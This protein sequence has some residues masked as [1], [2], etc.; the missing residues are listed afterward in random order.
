MENTPIHSTPM[1]RNDSSQVCSGAGISGQNADHTFQDS[2]VCQGQLAVLQTLVNAVDSNLNANLLMVTDVNDLACEDLSGLKKGEQDQITPTFVDCNKLECSKAYRR[3]HASMDEEQRFRQYEPTMSKRMKTQCDD[4]VRRMM[5]REI[6]LKYNSLSPAV[7]KE[8]I[9]AIGIPHRNPRE[10]CFPCIDDRGSVHLSR[11]DFL[12]PLSMSGMQQMPGFLTFNHV[13]EVGVSE[14]MESINQLIGSVAGSLS[15]KVM[16]IVSSILLLLRNFDSPLNMALCVST[17]AAQLGAGTF[18]VTKFMS[19]YSDMLEKLRPTIA[20]QGINDYVN[21]RELFVHIGAFLFLIVSVFILREIPGTKNFNEF[22]SRARFLPGACSGIKSILDFGRTMFGFVADFTCEKFLG[23]PRKIDGFEALKKWQKEVIEVSTVAYLEKI[24]TD[25]NAVAHVDN[26]YAQGLRFAASF[27]SMRVP[28]EEQSG[29]RLHMVS[30]S[31]I[32]NSAKSSGAINTMLRNEPLTLQIFGKSGVGKS[33]ILNLLATDLMI[34]RGA[35]TQDDVAN[36]LYSRKVGQE[37]WDGM[38]SSK[39]IVVYDDY[40]AVKDS[41]AKPNDELIELIHLYN[42]HPYALHM[43]ALIEKANTHFKADVVILTTNQRDF[44]ILSLSYPEAH[45]RRIDIR[46]ELTVDPKYG[47]ICKEGDDL[48]VRVDYSKVPPGPDGMILPYILTVV[49]ETDRGVVNTLGTYNYPQFRDFILAADRAKRQKN[50][51]LLTNLGAYM[52]GRLGSRSNPIVGVQTA[53]TKEEPESIPLRPIERDSEAIGVIPVPTDAD[54]LI[55]YLFG[56]ISMDQRAVAMSLF[57]HATKD[58]TRDSWFETYTPQ[59]ETLFQTLRCTASWMARAYGEQIDPVYGFNN[60]RSW[61]SGHS[62]LSTQ[63]Y[64]TGMR[65]FDPMINLD[66]PVLHPRLQCFS[67]PLHQVHIAIM[68]IMR[69]NGYFECGNLPRFILPFFSVAHRTATNQFPIN[70][71]SWHECFARSYG[72]LIS[73]MAPKVKLICEAHENPAGACISALAKV[74]RCVPDCEKNLCARLTSFPEKLTQ[75][76]WNRYIAGVERTALATSISTGNVDD[77]EF[78]SLRF[79]VGLALGLMTLLTGIGWAVWGFKILRLVSKWIKKRIFSSEEGEDITLPIITDDPADVDKLLFG[80]AENSGDP[81]TRAATRA[82]VV[83]APV[84]ENSGDPRTRAAPRHVVRESAESDV[85]DSPS[86]EAT[87]REVC[88]GAAAAVIRNLRAAEEQVVSDISGTATMPQDQNAS[89]LMGKILMRS[90]YKLEIPEEN[91]EWKHNVTI[92]FIEGRRAITVAHVV[93]RIMEVGKCR[94]RS[95]RYPNGLEFDAVELVVKMIDFRHPIYGQR[96]IVLIEFPPKVVMH[97]DIRC[98]LANAED[99]SDMSEIRKA[100]LVGHSAGPVIAGRVYVTSNAMAQKQRVAISAGTYVEH[101]YQIFGYDIET[102][103][104]ECGMILMSLSKE[105]CRKIVGI[106]CGGSKNPKATGFA[107]PISRGMY[108]ELTLGCDKRSGVS[109]PEF[110][111]TGVALGWTDERDIARTVPG[112]RD[113]PVPRKYYQLAYDIP[114]EGIVPIGYFGDRV[115]EQTKTKISESPI[116]DGIVDFKTAPAHL[117]PFTRDGI[118]YNPKSLARAKI[119]VTPSHIDKVL[120]E[121]AMW[122]YFDHIDHCSSR[123]PRLLT[124]PEA[125]RGVEGDEYIAPIDRASSPGYPFIKMRDGCKGKTKWLGKDEEWNVSHPELM[126]LIRD[127]I[128][129]GEH[130][131]RTPTIYYDPLKDERRPIA[132]VE[133]GKTRLFSV[134]PLDFNIVFRMYFGMFGANLMEN[135]IA[136]ESCVGMNPYSYAWTE[137]ARLLQSKGPGVLAGDFTN[138]DGTLQAEILWAILC[139]I[140]EWYASLDVKDDNVR[141]M[142]WAEIVN[143]VHLDGNVLYDWNQSQ[144]SGNPFTVLINSIYNSVVCRL[145]WLVVMTTAQP[146]WAN[147]ESFHQHVKIFNYGDDNLWNI[148]PEALVIFNMSTI[149]TAFESVG[150]HYTSESKDDNVSTRTL[151][152]VSF[153]KRKFRWDEEWKRYTAPLSLD[154]VLEMA[155]WVRGHASLHQLCATTLET[156]AYELSLHGREVFEEWIPRMRK[157]AKCLNVRPVLMTYDVYRRREYTRYIDPD[158]FFFNACAESFL[159]GEIPERCDSLEGGVKKLWLSDPRMT[160]PCSQ[161]ESPRYDIRCNPEAVEDTV[162]APV[163]GVYLMFQPEVKVL[164]TVMNDKQIENISEDES[165]S[166]PCCPSLRCDEQDIGRIDTP[167]DIT[168]SGDRVI[169]TITAQPPRTVTCLWCK[170]RLRKQQAWWQHCEGKHPTQLLA[171]SAGK[172]KIKC[173]CGK[174][175]FTSLGDYAQHAYQEHIAVS[176][177]VEARVPVIQG[178]AL[179]DNGSYAVPGEAAT[180]DQLAATGPGLVVSKQIQNITFEDQDD[181]LENSLPL[182]HATPSIYG[183][184]SEVRDHTVYDFLTRPYQVGTLNWPPTA[185]PGTPLFSFKFPENM[186]SLTAIRQKAA[187]FRFFRAGLKFTV[188]INAQP[189]QQGML[190]LVFVPYRNNIETIPSS[191]QSLRSITGYHNTTIDLSSNQTGILRVPYV[192]P[193]AFINLTTDLSVGY[194]NLGTVLGVVYGALKG[195]DPVTGT[196]WAEFTDVEIKVPTGMPLMNSA[197]SDAPFEPL[198]IAGVALSAASAALDATTA[199]GVE[200]GNKRVS[201]LA[202]EQTAA[203]NGT[204]TKIMNATSLVSGVASA[205]PFLTPVAAPVCAV[206]TVVGAIASLFGWSKPTV[207]TTPDPMQITLPRYLANYNGADASK[208]LALEA[209]NGIGHQ[210]VFGSDVDEMALRYISSRFNYWRGF[211]WTTAQVPGTTIFSDSVSPMGDSQYNIF[212]PTASGTYSPSHLS[213]TAE[214]FALWRGSIR[215]RLRFVKTKFHSGRIRIVLVPGGANTDGSFG[216]YDVQSCYSKIIDLSQV[217]EIDF[218]VPFMNIYPWLEN[219]HLDTLLRPHVAAI[220]VVVLNEL[221]RPNTIVADNIDV[222]VEK[223]GGDDLEF[224]QPRLPDFVPIYD[225]T[226]PP[227]EIQGVALSGWSMTEHQLHQDDV[228][229]LFRSNVR[230]LDEVDHEVVGERVVSVKQLLHRNYVMANQAL[231]NYFIQLQ[232]IRGTTFGVALKGRSFSDMYDWFAPLY[233][234]WRGGFRL[235]LFPDNNI[236]GA[237]AGGMSAFLSYPALSSGFSRL[238]PNG[239]KISSYTPTN[240]DDAGTQARGSFTKEGV[241]EF[242]VPYYGYQVMQ[243]SPFNAYIDHSLSPHGSVVSIKTASTTPTVFYRSVADDF[244]MGFLIGV[245]LVQKF[246]H[247]A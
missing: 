201:S 22:M 111:V 37:F 149:A 18:F 170:T 102:I 244:S 123:K 82:N 24:R 245:P 56:D 151:E 126:Q 101:I 104:G 147:M 145:V 240:N 183:A 29:F 116:H 160:D 108:D 200:L 138:F 86:L 3:I 119:I 167:G 15:D 125:I 177:V 239:P 23:H 55:R 84:L 90:S 42:N 232:A 179:M 169:C 198:P 225:S 161:L 136:M 146:E 60:V 199:V 158:A 127:R 79:K 134:A 223:A 205:I 94:I 133:A 39:K 228:A 47:H 203:S 57:K 186:F 218:T 246:D 92:T 53:F 68:S 9:D 107:S 30:L 26:L 162:S 229:P 10:L 197:P 98:H 182:P 238:I 192:C 50:E 154:T 174:D 97:P 121:E 25:S 13:V 207:E 41:E 66:V 140:N 65:H 129:E 59:D 80:V 2:D 213:Y 128:Y 95:S 224:A 152:D 194:I 110:D 70:S 6:C 217:N 175:R 76:G 188:Q 20:V 74:Q 122:D 171:T 109:L 85:F 195:S 21:W 196:M 52:D 120:L 48:V 58:F 31:S 75:I 113:R 33:M 103:P 148:S 100:A 83:E 36:A 173:F 17:I 178:V 139:G 187:R 130:R 32:M 222:L 114:L 54:G 184:G 181:V 91:G 227:T 16:G 144:P 172:A 163:M 234:Y 118:I 214:A 34:E 77:A 106:H 236:D 247:S 51:N 191:L 71:G 62:P 241:A 210:P 165:G 96:D 235:K 112:I 237:N 206:S 208:K 81:R 19:L 12:P 115:F 180:S 45:K 143:S 88:V 176:P 7:F 132:K 63:D 11:Q 93:P 216:T 64:I 221:R 117:R 215:Y 5:I 38:T 89:V 28:R 27:D 226:P 153:L 185:D 166:G 67:G 137:L 46:V 135:C 105:H 220:H 190:L 193:T 157:A 87:S 142:L 141:E 212:S 204:V 211:S 243:R 4:W 209:K 219:M 78:E 40:M 155:Q 168:S 131:R 61:F 231:G 73:L 156:A 189:F 164:R 99:F 72:F 159:A 230:E 44:N 233:A 8:W 49:S 1:F 242:E 202:R 35:K 43:A 14:T 150:M 124:I 69:R